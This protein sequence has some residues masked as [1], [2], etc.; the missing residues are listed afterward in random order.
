MLAMFAASLLVLQA[1]VHRFVHVPLDVQVAESARH[2]FGVIRPVLGRMFPA[3]A[4]AM[5]MPTAKNR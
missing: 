5:V 4:G 3:A 1:F 2:M